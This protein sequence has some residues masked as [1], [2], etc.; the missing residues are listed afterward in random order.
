MI[1]SFRGQYRFLSNFYPC[2]ISL[3]GRTFPNSEIPYQAAKAATGAWYEKICNASTPGDAKR[4]GRLV[5]LRP[6]W[7]EV[8]LAF[9]EEIVFQKFDQNEDLKK[10]LLDTGDEEL[11]EGNT[12]RDYFWGV[13]NGQGENNLGKILMKVRDQLREA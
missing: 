5:P 7:D 6:D 12:W 1:D 11:V 13:C 8:R 9:M 2:R 10:L 4:L 3:W